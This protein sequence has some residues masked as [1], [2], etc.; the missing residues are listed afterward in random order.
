MTDLFQLL[1]SG[2]SIGS[3]YALVGLGYYLVFIS[4]RVINFAHGALVQL[5]GV[6][7]LSLLVT[8]QLS[9]ASVFLMTLF[10]MAAVGILFDRLLVGPARRG[11]VLSSI[12]MTVGGFIFFEQ[13]IYVFW[14]KDELMFPSISGDRPLD[15]MGV[16]VVPQA[17]W[18]LGIT[19]LVLVV[20]WFFFSRSLL[21]SAMMAAAEKPEAALLMG[22]DVRTMT[23]LAWGLATSLAAVAGILIAPITFAGGSLSTEMGIKGFVAAVLGGITQAQGV[24]VGG[25]LLGVSEALTTGYVSSGWKDAISFALLIVILAARPQGLLGLT[26]REKV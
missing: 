14:T 25:L 22:I 16:M 11:D 10:I 1:V 12:L 26:Q 8:W 21:G 3:I 17:I 18:I 15:L 5:G 2:L 4:S 19:L 23:S 9:Y 24:V 6:V 7:A 20:L 13:M